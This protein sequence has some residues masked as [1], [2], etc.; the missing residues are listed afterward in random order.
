MCLCV[1][2]VPVHVPTRALSVG[3]HLYIIVVLISSGLCN[4]ANT[5]QAI[6]VGVKYRFLLIQM[7]V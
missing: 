4:K 1:V 3:L 6:H 2:R 5:V 7:V